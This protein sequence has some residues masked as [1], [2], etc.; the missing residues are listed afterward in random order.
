MP[1]MSK[2]DVS[3]KVCLELTNYLYCDKRRNKPRIHYKLCDLCRY[4]KKCISFKSFKEKRPDLYPPPVVKKRG[5][6]KKKKSNI[7]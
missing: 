4:N 5:S 6:P 1:R 3:T 2:P 7:K